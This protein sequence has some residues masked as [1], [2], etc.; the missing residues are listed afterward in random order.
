[1]P[2]ASLPANPAALRPNKRSKLR[3]TV[4][5]RRTLA[6]G[7]FEFSRYSAL[8]ALDLHCS[9]TRKSHSQLSE[10][11]A[12]SVVSEEECSNSLDESSATAFKFEP[13]YDA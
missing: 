6:N 9:R 13:S 5:L 4:Q 11:A 2:I 10:S 7:S 3:I 1:M 12:A 8:S